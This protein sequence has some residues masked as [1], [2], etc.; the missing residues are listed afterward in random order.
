VSLT[1]IQ[2]QLRRK[3]KLIFSSGRLDVTEDPLIIVRFGKTV[4]SGISAVIK[5]ATV[6]AVSV[7]PIPVQHYVMIIALKY[8]KGFQS[9]C[10]FAMVVKIKD[11]V[12]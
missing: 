1:R 12:H 2:Q 10:M 4:L 8:A 7:I 6:I 5:S 11:H 3:S 9:L